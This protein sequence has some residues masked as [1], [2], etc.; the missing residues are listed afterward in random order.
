MGDKGR[1]RMKRVLPDKEKTDKVDYEITYDEEACKGALTL[2]SNA[3]IFKSTFSLKDPGDV[4]QDD[5]VMI[6]SII[7]FCSTQIAQKHESVKAYLNRHRRVFDGVLVITYFVVFIEMPDIEFIDS[8][9]IN[10]IHGVRPSLICDPIQ[11]KPMEGGGLSLKII[12]SS[13]NSPPN[14]DHVTLTRMHFTRM[15]IYTYEDK[16]VNGTVKRTRKA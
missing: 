3:K 1:R 2:P 13:V 10:D 7:T 4:D 9:Q 14:N 16:P 11:I 5:L 6:T 15:D 8:R 12:A